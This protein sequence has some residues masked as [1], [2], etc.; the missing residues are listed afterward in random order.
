MGETPTPEPVA[1]PKQLP[2]YVVLRYL[3]SDNQLEVIE[4]GV[5]AAND[6]A[7]IKAAVKDPGL[8]VAVPQRS[9]RVRTLS[10]ESVP[11]VRIA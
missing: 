6:V 8:Y 3:H 9:F 11:V 4:R 1:A 10:T 5:Q 2:E 7:A